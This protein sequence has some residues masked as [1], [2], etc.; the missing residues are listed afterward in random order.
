M[1][2]LNQTISKLDRCQSA[3]ELKE[4]FSAAVKEIGYAGFDAFSVRSG[5]AGDIDQEFNFYVGD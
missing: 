2:I 5:T 1:E 3:D 4:V